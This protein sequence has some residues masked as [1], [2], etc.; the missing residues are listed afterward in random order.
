MSRTIPTDIATEIAKESFASY[1]IYIIVLDNTTVYFTNHDQEITFFDLNNASQKYTPLAITRNDIHYDTDSFI[2]HVTVSLD[3]INQA[4]GS[5][6]AN[7]EFRGR[8]MVIRKVFENFL[9]T[10]SNYVTVFD[11]L[12]DRPSLSETSVAVDVVSRGGTLARQAPRRMY[13]V[14]CGWKFGSVE[15]NYDI[16]GNSATGVADAT[17]TTTRLVDSARVES[18]NHWKYGEI[19]ITSGTS[20]NQSRRVVISSGANITVDVAFAS[21]LQ[22]GDHYKIRRGCSKTFVWC[23]GLTNL[24]NYGGFPHIPQALIV[25]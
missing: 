11:G 9:D 3:N 2:N 24:D 22:V 4:L 14:S 12:M 8:R 5:Y 1:E 10:S 18:D 15:C 23:S 6:V 20:I 16:E 13:T 21:G 7:N 17:T 25:R 19:L